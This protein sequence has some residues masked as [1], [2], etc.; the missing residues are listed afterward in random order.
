MTWGERENGGDSEAVREQLAGG[1]QHIY[2]TDCTFAALKDD[3][4]PM[5]EI[6][7]TKSKSKRRSKIKDQKLEMKMKHETNA[8]FMVVS[9]DAAAEAAAPAA[10]A[11]A[12]VFI[13]IF[14]SNLQIFDF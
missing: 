1:V 4:T 3:G 6:K 14:I 11:A 9:R 13:S 8:V 7:G 12:S 5:C 2:S 10:A